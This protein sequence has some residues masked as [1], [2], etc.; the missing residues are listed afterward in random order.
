M[1]ATMSLPLETEDLAVARVQ[2]R[3]ALEQAGYED[4]YVTRRPEGFRISGISGGRI[5]AMVSTILPPL[6]LLGVFARTSIEARC[7]SS[8]REGDSKLTLN[9]RV[10]ALSEFDDD[11]EV[12]FVFRGMGEIVGDTFKNRRTLKNVA[13]TLR[14]GVTVSAE[15][16]TKPEESKEDRRAAF[17][18]RYKKGQRR[19]N[20]QLVT[21]AVFFSLIAVLYLH[22]APS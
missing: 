4:L 3:K 21:S 17:Q 16:L 6:Q 5:A 14:A 12:N 2:V 18:A 1:V 11:P 10:G 13:R 20:I 7:R 9:V 8:L 15:E 22:F 19:R